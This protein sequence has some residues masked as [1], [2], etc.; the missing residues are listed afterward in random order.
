[1]LV[2]N[3]SENSGS[4]FPGDRSTEYDQNHLPRVSGVD[5]CFPYMLLVSVEV[6]HVSGVLG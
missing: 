4:I 6:A 1:L 3:L 2:E 5:C